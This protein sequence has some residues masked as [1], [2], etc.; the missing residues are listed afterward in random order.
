MSF[1]G[2]FIDQPGRPNTESLNDTI[3][4]IPR[5]SE[6]LNFNIAIN[7]TGRDVGRLASI[8]IWAFRALGAV[9]ALQPDAFGGVTMR[10]VLGS[11]LGSVFGAAF[12]I[13]MA[14]T[15]LAADLPVHNNYYTAPPS[16]SASSWAGPYLGAQFGRSRLQLAVR[17]ICRRR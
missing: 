15:A 17:S 10:T 12:S 6:P 1:F 11:V 4:E 5:D 9:V 7:P 8:F 14:G 3:A 13:A 2:T 16:Y